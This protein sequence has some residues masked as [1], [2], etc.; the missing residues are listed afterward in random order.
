MS[1]QLV[2]LDT[3]PLGL[4]THPKPSP[5]AQACIAW[6]QNLLDNDVRVLV[7]AIAD[8]ELRR[9]YLLR[10]NVISLHKLDLIL[11]PVELLPLTDDALHHAAQLWAQTRQRGRPT[12]DV[13]ALDGDCILVAQVQLEVA[14]LELKEDEWMIATTDVGDLPHLAPAKRW[15]EIRIGDTER[16]RDAS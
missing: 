6:L 14:R 11:Q 15:N 7:P 12:S 8:Y 13:K 16:S 5:D 3:G 1:L 9:E 10:R 2:A 4:V